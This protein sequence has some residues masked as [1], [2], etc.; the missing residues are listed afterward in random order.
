MG[1]LHNWLRSQHPGLRTYRTFHVM[2]L[3]AAHNDAK[4][5]AVYRL[6]S[7]LTSGYAATFDEEPLPVDVA[8]K[9]YQRLLDL[10]DKAELSIGATIEQQLEVL[11]EIAAA[12]LY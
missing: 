2:L 9:A 6:L 8:D 4:H 10:V 1:E 5:R 12:E 11:N 3:K 7:N